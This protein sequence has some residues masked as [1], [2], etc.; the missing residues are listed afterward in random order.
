LWA[1]SDVVNFSAVAFIPAVDGVSVIAV[2]PA[3]DGVFAVASFPA[4]PCIPMLFLLV[5]LH[6]VLNSK[7]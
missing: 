4:D 7:Q 5:S 3:I 6:T 1:S 2:F